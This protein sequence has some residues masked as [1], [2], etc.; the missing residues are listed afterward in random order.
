MTANEQLLSPACVMNKCFSSK[1]D[2]LFSSLYEINT[3]RGWYFN[4]R[5]IK[6]I[7]I[8]FYII[9]M[10]SPLWIVIF[11]N[12][13][14]CCVIPLCLYFN[15]LKVH[16]YIKGKYRLMIW[17]VE[18]SKVQPL[19]FPD[20]CKIKQSGRSKLWNESSVWILGLQFLAKWLRTQ[21]L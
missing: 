15:L 2:A 3:H 13:T 7:Q 11:Y 8:I 19:H 16:G 9:L 10:C 20:Y 17:R 14:Y 5:N 21:S 18:L 12:V 4:Q 1:S 6:N